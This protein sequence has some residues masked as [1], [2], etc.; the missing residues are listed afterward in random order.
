MPANLALGLR[1]DDTDVDSRSLAP[2]YNSLLWLTANELQL[3]QDGGAFL[4]GEGSYDYWLPNV[5]FDIEVMEGVVLRGSY[6][7]TISRA[8]YKDLQAG[9]T[10]NSQARTDAASTGNGGDPNLQPFESE[11]FDFSAE[12]YYAEGSY[13]SV[14]YYLK[15]VDNFIGTS[16]VNDVVYDE[17]VQP[18]S[19]PREQ[20][21]LANVDDPDDSL[22]ILEYYRAAGLG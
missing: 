21:A 2:N 6:S 8:N 1:Y 7:E 4:S 16:V 13:V 18:R 10:V 3:Q 12:W 11:N 15:K 20:E 9:R 5:D 17:L 14:G 19:G 22:Q